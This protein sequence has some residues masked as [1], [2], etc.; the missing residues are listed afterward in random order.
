MIHEIKEDGQ[1]IAK[2]ADN[3]EDA[4]F[5]TILKQLKDKILQEKVSVEL[6]QVLIDYLEK[7]RKV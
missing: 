3:K 7:K 2:I 1:T 6:D 4:T 5:E